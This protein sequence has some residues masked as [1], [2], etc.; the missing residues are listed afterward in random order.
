MESKKTFLIINQTAGSPYHGMV[1]R[2]YYLANEW[3]KQ[4]HKAI[5]ISGSY[6]HNF[7]KL[8]ETSGLFTKEVIDGIEYWWVKMPNYSKSRSIGR[9]LTLF[10]FPLLL[11]FFPFWRLAKPDTVIVSGPPHVSIVNAWL[12][13][14]IWGAKLIYEVRDIWPLTIIKL[15]NVSPWHPVILILTFFERFAYKVSDRVVS[16]LSLAGKY[17]E[18]KG[19]SP[20]KFAYIP[21]GVDVSKLDL[22]DGKVSSK[23]SEI[24]KTKKIVI[25]TGSFG[26]ANN[27][28]QL[29]DSA[30]LLQNDESL[31]FVFVGDGPFRKRLEEKAFKLNN[32]TIFGPV[33]KKEIPLILKYSS[34]CYVGLMKSDLFSHGVSPNK[35]FDYM[36]AGRPVIMAIDTEDKIVEKAECGIAVPTCLPEDIASAIRVLLSKKADELNVMG[37]NGRSY[38]ENNH[39]YQSLSKIYLQVADS[40]V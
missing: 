13:S 17:F 2:N 16:V 12:W 39:S 38:L 22:V 32:V 29:L 37:Q 33:P 36:A 23:L 15:G 3:V 14:R 27:L 35:L 10:I 25:Y 24:S 20:E 18:S 34:I 9:L 28:E 40:I 19:M 26:I 7:S 31:Q 1:Y 30:R 8:P 4:G 6:F 21:N 11:L 5:I